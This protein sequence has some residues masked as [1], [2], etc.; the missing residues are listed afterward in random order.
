[1]PELAAAGPEVGAALRAYATSVGGREQLA[2]EC[3]ADAVEIIPRSLAEN[4]GMDAIDI[5]VGLRSA[6][7]AGRKGAGVDAGGKAPIDAWT[8][9]IIEPLVVKKQA[10]ETAAEV[11]CMILRIDRV[12]AS[13]PRKTPP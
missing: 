1:M 2:I 3:F 5:L 13:T 8:A 7:A 9:G 4:A 12:I 10:L 6:H 11:A